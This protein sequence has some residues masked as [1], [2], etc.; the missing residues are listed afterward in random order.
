ML[1]LH[2]ATR[3]K[4]WLESAR[5]L[6]DWMIERFYSD[7][8]GFYFTS[9]EHEDL[10]LRFKDPLDGSTPSG[11]GV[12]SSVLL[13]LGRIDRNKK[14]IRVAEST[15][16]HFGDLMRQRPRETESMLEAL[17]YLRDLEKAQTKVNKRP[18]SR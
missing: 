16:N 3:A 9:H 11:N 13:R 2:E 18:F 1:D 15:L 7:D 10:I 5:R 17:G 6:A 12:A 4:R 14:Y 8:D